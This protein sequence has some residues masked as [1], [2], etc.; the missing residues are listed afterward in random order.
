MTPEARARAKIDQLMTAAGWLV[1]DRDEMNLGAGLGV[2]VR[3][4]PLATGPCDYLLF[5]DRKACG[6]IEA[7]PEG[8][9]LTGIAEQAEDYIAALPSHLQSWAPNLLFD[10]ESTG[11]E[12]HLG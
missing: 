5:I 12:T 2:A 7:K 9:T 11:T 1:Q 10:Y 3:E 6:A 8:V 4:Y